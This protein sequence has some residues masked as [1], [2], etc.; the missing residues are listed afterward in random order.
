[1]R[2]KMPSSDTLDTMKIN[3]DSRESIIRQAV[4]DVLADLPKPDLSDQIVVT[5]WVHAQNL[6]PAQV[7]REI[8]YHMTSGVRKPPAGSLLEECTGR[9]LDSVDFDS[10]GR[11]G[12]VRVGFPLEDAHSRRRQPV[13]DGYFAHNCRRGRVRAH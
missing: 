6:T 7:G 2:V 5:Y 9:V 13:F 11:L 8:S 4:Y 10:S 1:M 3:L 12:V